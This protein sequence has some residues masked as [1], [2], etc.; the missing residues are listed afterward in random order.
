MGISH[1]IKTTHPII[2]LGVLVLG[3]GR[4]SDN[5]RD[6]QDGQGEGVKVQELHDEFGRL[7]LE[8]WGA[9]LIISKL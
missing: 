8:L 2:A 6:G 3:I 1:Q 9:W 4:A 5:G 7:A